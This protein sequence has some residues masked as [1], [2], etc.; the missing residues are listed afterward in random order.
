MNPQHEPIGTHGYANHTPTPKALTVG[1]NSYNRLATNAA[2]HPGNETMRENI[3]KWESR[4]TKPKKGKK[5]G[6]M[7]KMQK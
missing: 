4:R 3:L 6:S 1:P 7:S 5:N 2:K